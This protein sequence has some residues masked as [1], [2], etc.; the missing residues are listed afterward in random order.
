MFVNSEGKVLLV[1]EELVESL[2]SPALNLVL[3]QRRLAV[4][5][6]P[7]RLATPAV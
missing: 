5:G 4:E 3:A 6:D 1:D 2:K 7:G